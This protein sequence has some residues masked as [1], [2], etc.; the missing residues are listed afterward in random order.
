MRA[1]RLVAHAK[2]NL[3]LDVL[4]PRGDGYHEV[5]SVMA[6][7]SLADEVR[8]ARARRWHVVVRPPLRDVGT[9]ELAERAARAL[10]GRLGRTDAARVIVRKRVPIAAGLGG[11]SSDAAH[12]LKAL[13]ALWRAS[14]ALVAEVAAATGSDVPFFLDGALAEVRGRGEQVRPLAGGPWHGVLVLPHCRVSTAEAYARLDLSARSDGAR[15]TALVR[16]VESG[17]ADAAQ[18]RGLCGNDLD[19][20]ASALCPQIADIRA[21]VPDVPLFLSGSGPGLFAIADHRGQALAIRRRLRR[22]QVRAI[23]VLIG[24]S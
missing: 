10:A 22:A 2:V 15:T 4:G 12:V 17:S 7:I 6:R 21:H 16:C 3:T 5:R 20:V 18:L 11:G 13:G 9:G 1:V 24:V 23:A 19:A 14:G 8:V